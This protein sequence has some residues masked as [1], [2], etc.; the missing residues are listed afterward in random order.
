[1]SNKIQI[2]KAVEIIES[3]FAPL[4]CMCETQNRRKRISIRIYDPTKNKLLLNIE[5]ILRAQFLDRRR[6]DFIINTAR[7]NLIN[8]DYNLF[9]RSEIVAI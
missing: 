6:L 4:V 1:M 3:A 8:R 5:N 9:T 2:E 7:S